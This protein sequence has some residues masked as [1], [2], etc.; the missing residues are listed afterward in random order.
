MGKSSLAE[1]WQD[2]GKQR[3]AFHF[4]KQVAMILFLPVVLAN[5]HAK[6]FFDSEEDDSEDKNKVSQEMPVLLPAFAVKDNALPFPVGPV[7]TQ[8][9]AIDPGSL[10]VSPDEIR[11]TLLTT[12]KSGA[13][14]IS[15]EGIRCSTFQMKRYAFGHGNGTWSLSRESAWA[16]ITFLSANRPEAVLAQDYFCLEGTVAGKPEQMLDRIRYNRSLQS[17]KYKGN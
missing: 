4:A 8:S 14:N 13:K 9:F 12:S 7:A 16:P 10:T 15:Y 2:S 6:G 3:R 5:A 1:S 17:E 11:F